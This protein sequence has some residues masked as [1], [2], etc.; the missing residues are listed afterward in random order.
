MFS[1]LL[2]FIYWLG[3]FNDMSAWELQTKSCQHYSLTCPNRT[4]SDRFWLIALFRQ[5][6]AEW[7]KRLPFSLSLS[8][9]LH[10]AREQHTLLRFVIP[11]TLSIR[12]PVWLHIIDR[13]LF[14]GFRDSSWFLSSSLLRPCSI[15]GGKQCLVWDHHLPAP[16]L[17]DA[18][19]CVNKT[20]LVRTVASV[21]R[22]L[23]PRECDA[24]MTLV[25]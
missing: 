5:G 13:S 15:M 2:L 22:E 25:V 8:L 16:M 11:Q 20:E 23:L 10:R 9:S 1:P 18:L 17:L 24:D 14:V 3:V 4:G 12:W 6:S 21:S 19:K 7:C